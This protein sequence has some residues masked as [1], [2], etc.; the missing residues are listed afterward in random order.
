M[1]IAPV[2]GFYKSKGLSFDKNNRS[3]AVV[4][5]GAKLVPP[6]EQFNELRVFYHHIYEYK[7]GLR[8]LVLTTEKSYNKPFIE[9]RLKREKIPYVI[10]KVSEKAINVFFGNKD[11]IRIVKT[12]DKRL[13][14]ITPEQDFMLGIM[15]GYDKILQCKRYFVMQNKFLKKAL[16]KAKSR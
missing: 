11:C 6:T 16:D 10:N 2:F 9:D 13:D 8:S 12:F 1:N 3:A 4:A 7:K 14:K 15:L 5:F